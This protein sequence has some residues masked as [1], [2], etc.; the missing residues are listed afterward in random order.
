MTAKLLV[1]GGTAGGSARGLGN[2][3]DIPFFNGVLVGVVLILASGG[4]VLEEPAFLLG[5]EFAPEFEFTLAFR[6][7]F[8]DLL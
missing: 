7:R 8:M 6:L 5:V 2:F 4:A 1:L 3:S